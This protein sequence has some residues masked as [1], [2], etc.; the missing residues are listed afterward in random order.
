MDGKT[1]RGVL[2]DKDGTL[3]GF[4]ATWGAWAVE[5]VTDLACGDPTVAATLAQAL[6]LDMQNAEFQPDSPVI[7]G[8][9]GD[10]IQLILQ[11]VPQMSL[12]ELVAFMRERSAQVIPVEAT[13]LTPLLNDLAARDLVLGVATNDS[14]A[15]ARAQLTRVG[16]LGAFAFL[17][18]YDS[19]H[20]A[21]PE[22]GQCFAFAAA[23]GLHPSEVAMVGDSTH[24]MAAGRAAGMRTVAVLTGPAKADDLAPHADVVLADI[25]LLPAWLDSL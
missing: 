20:G 8:T 22:P 4:Q 1:V 2:F 24:D 18:G 3:F 13:A 17:A 11:H 6:R 14:E 7:A 5:L 25:G 9:D 16:A 15:G 23:V 21:K 10:A 19:G 12:G